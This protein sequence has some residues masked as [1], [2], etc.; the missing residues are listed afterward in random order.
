MGRPR[1][2]GQPRSRG[3]RRLGRDAIHADHAT[4]PYVGPRLGKAPLD[5]STLGRIGLSEREK[6]V[7]VAW[8]QTESKDLVA[9]RLYIA[10]TTVRTHLQ[11]A[12]AT[13]DGILSLKDL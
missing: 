10:P 6:E 4:T 8:F 5:D 1:D 2:I 9:K 3:H 13:E 11:R 12:R 7:L